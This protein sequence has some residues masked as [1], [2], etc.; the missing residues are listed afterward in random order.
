MNSKVV[1]ESG[2]MD[3][4]YVIQVV[5]GEESRTLQLIRMIVEPELLI[6]AYIPRVE[7]YRK[8][9]GEWRV[10]KEILFPGYLFVV[11]DKIDELYYALKGVPLF[12]K[13]LGADK[14]FLWPLSEEEVTFLQSFCTD[15]HHTVDMSSGYIVG[16]KVT[17]TSGPLMGKEA[18]IK[19][20]DRH[21]R[22][23]YLE[24]RFF[25]QTL[26]SKVGLEIIR[27]E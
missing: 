24:T 23:A 20:I 27:K 26:I 8:Y 10:V 12:T 25:N 7:Q 13:L 2:V 14:K 18:A 19:K 17:I 1:P 9:R 22:I 21:K 11:S 15:K 5:S 4:H 6:D 16:D 3:K